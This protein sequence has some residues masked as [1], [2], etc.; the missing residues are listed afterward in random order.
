MEFKE[1]ITKYNNV[2]KV[3]KAD[4]PNKEFEHYC[5]P[6]TICTDKILSDSAIYV[7][8]WFVHNG[9]FGSLVRNNTNKTEWVV[10][11]NGITDTFTLTASNQNPKKCDIKSYMD[12]FRKSFDMKC[13]IEKLKAIKNIL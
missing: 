5:Q 7:I 4:N 10:T 9:F 8:W 3:S 6:I 12:S 11:R 1:F 13:E 2:W